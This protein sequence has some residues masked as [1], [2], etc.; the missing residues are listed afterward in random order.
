M[1]SSNGV[2]LAR[3]QQAVEVHLLNSWQAHLNHEIRMAAAHKSARWDYSSETIGAKT[4]H[5]STP[6]TAQMHLSR[7]VFCRSPAQTRNTRLLGFQWVARRRVKKYLQEISRGPKRRARH[8][9]TQ[10]ASNLHPKPP[11][12]FP[13]RLDRIFSVE[14]ARTQ[15]RL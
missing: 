9:A 10:S 13:R 5:E 6:K 4:V 2:L 15:T 11:R 7:R 3:D 1:T 14:L 12:S 8:R